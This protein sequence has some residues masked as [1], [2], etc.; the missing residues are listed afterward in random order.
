[1][2]LDPAT[3]ALG[4]GAFAIDAPSWNLYRLI[5]YTWG[6]S[7]SKK[8]PDKQTKPAK[9]LTLSKKKLRTLSIIDLSLA[10]GGSCDAR[11][12]SRVQ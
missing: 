4:E 6:N 5:T 3:S 2:A 1:M 12:P 11:C 9:R 8:S 7:M 10:V